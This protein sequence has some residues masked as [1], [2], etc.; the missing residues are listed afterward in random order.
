MAVEN[1]IKRFC[2]LADSAKAGM[3]NMYDAAFQALDGKL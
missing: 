2:E 3:L 1:T